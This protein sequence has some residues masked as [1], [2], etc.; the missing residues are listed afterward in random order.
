[1]FIANRAIVGLGL[2][3]LDKVCG[4]ARVA[5]L[6]QAGRNLLLADD[7]GLL[8]TV[9]ADRDPTL[10]VQKAENLTALVLAF[11]I[12]TAGA[13]LVDV[14]ELFDHAGL[15]VSSGKDLDEGAQ[16]PLRDDVFAAFLGARDDSALH[17][18]FRKEFCF[19]LVDHVGLDAVLADEVV[20]VGRDPFGGLHLPAAPTL[21]RH[22]HHLLLRVHRDLIQKVL[23]ILFE[24]SDHHLDLSELHP[25]EL[26]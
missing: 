4:L 17:L 13:H 20:A 14:V 12:S 3:F 23:P 8:G 9:Q 22:E 21:R 6:A 25:C 11:R 15:S 7:A 5:A 16:E 26:P 1:M 2:G 10:L 24:L 19:K 18:P